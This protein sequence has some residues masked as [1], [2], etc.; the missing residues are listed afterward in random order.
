MAPVEAY[1]ERINE[2]MAQVHWMDQEESARQNWEELKIKG[3]G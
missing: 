2:L 3:R 1:T